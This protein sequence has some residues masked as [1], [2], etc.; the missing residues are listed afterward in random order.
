MRSPPNRARQL[1]LIA[2][3]EQSL[4]WRVANH[5]VNNALASIEMREKLGDEIT[6][7]DVLVALN[8]AFDA[9]GTAQ[10]YG[11]ITQSARDRATV[12]V[13]D[14]WDLIDALRL[15]VERLRTT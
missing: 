7:S 11:E 2:A 8:S 14:E 1:L 10:H 15:S 9:L 6:R 5:I 12:A 4:G 3:A 13:L